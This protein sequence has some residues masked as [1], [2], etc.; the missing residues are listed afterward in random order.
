[1]LFSGCSSLKKNNHH[2]ITEH[3]NINERTKKLTKL[4]HWKIN[5]KMA[6]MSPKE[7]HS[8]TLNWHY[9][10]NKNRQTLNLT[11]VL[12][13][14]VFNLESNNGLHI[15][16]AEGKRYQSPD[17]N[18]LL[19]SLT[20]FTLPTQAMTYWLKGLP[21]LNNDEIAY[22]LE[23][24]LPKTLVSFYDEKKWSLKYGAY[25]QV[26]EYQLATKFTIK[27]EDLTLKLN[28]HQWDVK[29]NDQ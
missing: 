25:Q 22:N 17:L 5:G 2:Q 3:Q 14:Q 27:Q 16:Q 24:Q 11:T 15:V 13:F 28:V 8:V 23:T 7:R 26:G 20:G 12:G 10:G 6:I 18:K 29:I 1:M 9:Q 4:S 19:S 21:Y